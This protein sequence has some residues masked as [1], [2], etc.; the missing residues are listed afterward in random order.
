MLTR[1]QGTHEIHKPPDEQEKA[2]L[3]KACQDFES[4]FIEILLKSMRATVPKDGLTGSFSVET[5]QA[6][7][8]SELAKDLARGRG[9]GLAEVLFN[10]LMRDRNKRV[11]AESVRAPKA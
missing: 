3:R 11:I 7:L 6:M 8:D 9:I 1:V 5:Y 2:K 10:E 4:V